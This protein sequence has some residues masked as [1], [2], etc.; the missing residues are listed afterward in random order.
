MVPSA[1]KPD[2]IGLDETPQDDNH[3]FCYCG[4]SGRVVDRDDG[5]LGRTE[6]AQTSL[7]RISWRFISA[8]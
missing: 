1:K 8:K 4:D 3:E 2:G 5:E 7:M 6:A